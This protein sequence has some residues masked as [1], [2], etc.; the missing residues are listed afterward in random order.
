MGSGEWGMQERRLSHS[1][2]ATQT[3]AISDEPS[4]RSSPSSPFFLRPSRRSRLRR[5]VPD[6]HMF[7]LLQS[8]RADDER[9][10]GH[11]DDPIE[12]GVGIAPPLLL[13]FAAR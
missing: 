10:Q 13:L 9:Q 7:Q 5:L 12:A 3:F 4:R 6:Q 2:F 8:E 1:A 11:A